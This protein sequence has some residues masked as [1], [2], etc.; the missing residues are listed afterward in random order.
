MQFM[1]YYLLAMP[2]ISNNIPHAAQPL[3]L[4]F[5]KFIFLFVHRSKILP[6]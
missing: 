1:G 4:H 2:P 5:E 3:P 6:K